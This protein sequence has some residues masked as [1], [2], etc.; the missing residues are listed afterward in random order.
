VVKSLSRSL[1]CQ[2]TGSIL[3]S[4]VFFMGPFWTWLANPP[5]PW[6]RREPCGRSVYAVKLPS[7]LF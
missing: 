7:N 5:R 4:T 2:S 3:Q 1:H 6:C